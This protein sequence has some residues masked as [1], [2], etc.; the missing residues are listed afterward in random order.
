M[1]EIKK[2]QHGWV[3]RLNVSLIRA[4]EEEGKNGVEA[5]FQEIRAQD[6]PE[7]LAITKRLKKLSPK[8]NKF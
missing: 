7:W 1:D 2:K 5:I 8:Q 4:I 3:K 6:L